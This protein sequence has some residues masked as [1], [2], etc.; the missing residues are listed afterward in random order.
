[1]HVAS[2]KA[3][4]ACRSADGFRSIAG[5]VQLPWFVGTLLHPVSCATQ[6]STVV[7]QHSVGLVACGSCL[8]I[9]GVCS[10]FV[11][12]L[13]CGA[14]DRPQAA[15]VY[16]LTATLQQGLC[17]THR[18]LAWHPRPLLLVCFVDRHR[19]VYLK[20]NVSNVSCFVE[21]S[22]ALASACI[23]R[24]TTLVGCKLLHTTQH[25]P[26]TLLTAATEGVS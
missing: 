2:H 14:P 16:H 18:T 6:D 3:C 20:P 9:T 8:L 12:M 5:V 22:T 13:D 11:Q 21:Q 7:Q 1:V 15:A 23:M 10:C 26:Y 24:Y 4:R 19:A 17:C 25:L